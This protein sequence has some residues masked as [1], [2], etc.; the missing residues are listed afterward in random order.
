MKRIDI[1]RDTAKRL[2]SRRTGSRCEGYVLPPTPTTSRPFNVEADDA[3][4]D[5]AE[6][7]DAEADE[8]ETH[9]ETTNE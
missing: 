4:A 5:D 9:D 2:S 3:E 1:N 7:D 6:A 8:V